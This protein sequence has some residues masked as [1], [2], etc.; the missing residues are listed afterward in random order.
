MEYLCNTKDEPFF[1]EYELKTFDFKTLYKHSATELYRE[2][3][4]GKTQQRQIED[5]FPRR[6][7]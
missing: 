3:E 4:L 2:K 1:S 6:A 7:W 5:V